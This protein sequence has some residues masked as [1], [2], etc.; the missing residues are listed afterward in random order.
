MT[1]SDRFGITVAISG[2]AIQAR[3][4]SANTTATVFSGRRIGPRSESARPSVAATPA[5]GRPSRRKARRVSVSQQQTSMTSESGRANIIHCAKPI[6]RPFLR[7]V[8][9]EEGVG[10]RA[11]QCRNAADAGAIRDREQERHVESAARRMNAVVCNRDRDDRHRDRHHHHGGG[12]VRDPH[13]EEGG[14]QHETADKL[15]RAG[16]G[17]R[18]NMER[19][20]LVKAGRLHR[21][22]DE[23]AAEK[24]KDDRIGVRRGRRADGG[25][26]EQ[27]K[28][29]KRQEAGRIDRD[30][31]R[32][33]PDRHQR[34]QRREPPA[35]G[36]KPVRRR[37]RQHQ[38]G[39]G[40]AGDNGFRIV[41][42]A[43]G[44]CRL[45][46]HA[47]PPLT[48]S[49]FPTVSQ[50]PARHPSGDLASAYLTP[51]ARVWRRDWPRQSQLTSC[52]ERRRYSG[53]SCW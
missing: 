18:Q 40:K 47:P 20:A 10:R 11:D 9:G 35:L 34:D 8:A 44:L 19:D 32:H 46:R 23:E 24:E 41:G 15:A 50:K 38:P 25:D 30:R 28:A 3:A 17:A 33:P 42:D 51:R 4:A 43:L 48:P 14:S 16:A 27:R 45:R 22:G 21:G 29:D 53:A 13:R 39:N 37:Q 26:V 12:G 7:H 31:F 5:M 6:S 1:V 2:C 36:R 52:R 49:I